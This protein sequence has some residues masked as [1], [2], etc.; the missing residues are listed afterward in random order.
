MS[1]IRNAIQTPDG[2][3]LDSLHTHDFKT[4]IDKITGKLY[5]VDGGLSYL[6]RIGDM[7]DCIDL[8][9]YNEEG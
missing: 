6:R 7:E 5:G 3:I 9:K 8:S 4:H 2:T 1:L